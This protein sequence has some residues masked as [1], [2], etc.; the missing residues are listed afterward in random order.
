VGRT[1]TLP[2]T[3]VAAV[4]LAIFS[5]SLYSAGFF[6]AYDHALSSG[7][8]Y[9]LHLGD[10]LY[11][12]GADPAEFGNSAGGT[13][14]AALGRVAV[15]AKDIVSLDDYRQRYAQYRSDASLQA[16]HARLPF[17]TIWD[18]HEFANNA[19]TDGAENH[20]PATQGDWAARKAAAAQA[21]HEWMPI[22]SPDPANLLTIYR[23]F[24]FGSLLTLHML[25]T[26]IEGRARQYDG[27]GDAD[28]GYTRYGTALASG[29]DASH[30]MISPTQFSWLQDGLARSTAVWQLLGNQDIMARM[31][32]PASVLQVA[33]TD[34]A[35]AQ[36]AVTAYLTAKATR[37]Q[38]GAAALTPQ[39]AA[40]LDAT[41]NPLLPYNLDAWDGY[42]LQRE[43]LLQTAV[44]LG[45]RL[46]TVSGDSHNAWFTH[47]TT[48]VGQ[49][50]GVEFAGSSVT[51]P[52]FESAGLGSFGPA[53][54]GRAVS[55]GVVD[56]GLGLVDDLAWADTT[57]RGYLL[58]S[59]NRSEV[60]GQYVFV[61]TVSSTSY[62]AAIG[63]TV[64]VDLSGQA[65]FSA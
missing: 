61:D 19:W 21:Y 62:T 6:N 25:D 18:D 47:L 42:P 24:D 23:R 60:Q 36:A 35:A 59:L 41:L 65:S 28:G 29:S 55:G 5:C 50:V 33:T 58:L 10:Y 57:R 22:R 52:G 38:A 3:D 2:A 9:A 7:A 20:D 14:A 53:L 26:R 48:L 54:D 13:T 31:W 46:V 1:R 12:Y 17:I 34:P 8:D 51:S 4:K 44:S 39:Q 16:L 30:P 43:A 37:A 15:P 11:E 63:Q 56:T 40:L 45:K 64:T 27:F 49:R 32:I